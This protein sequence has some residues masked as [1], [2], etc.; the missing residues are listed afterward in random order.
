[1]LGWA[2]GKTGSLVPVFP[3]HSAGNDILKLAALIS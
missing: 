1:M 2:R 3:L